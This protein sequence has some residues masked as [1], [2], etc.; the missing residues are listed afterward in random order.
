MFQAL[1]KALGLN[2]HDYK[3]GLTRVF[4]RPGK[5]SSSAAAGTLAARIKRKHS[6]QGGTS[7]RHVV[8]SG[9]ARFTNAGDKQMERSSWRRMNNSAF[10][11]KRRATGAG[12]TVVLTINTD[13]SLAVNR[14]ADITLTSLWRRRTC[15]PEDQLSLVI[16]FLLNSLK[17][18]Q[19]SG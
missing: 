7:I 16:L 14:R 12:R 18:E 9:E 4:F 17:P 3:F 15:P 5:V 6:E 1:F 13:P 11:V 10:G 2:E 8:C 19:D